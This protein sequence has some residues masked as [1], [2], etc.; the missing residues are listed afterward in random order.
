M[1][2]FIKLRIDTEPERILFHS[3]IEFTSPVSLQTGEIHTQRHGYIKQTAN[4]NGLV[5]DYIEN[6]NT[7]SNYFELSGSLHKY[8]HNGI[9]N[10]D[11]DLNELSSSIESVCSLLGIAPNQ[12]KVHRLEFGVNVATNY[13]TNDVL[14][15]I[16]CYMGKPY[17]LREFNGN[18]YF[19]RFALSQ[20]DVKIYNKALQYGLNTNILRFEIKVNRMD[21]L[22]KKGVQIVSIADLL[23]PL[24]NQQLRTQLNNT[25][26]NLLFIDYRINPKDICSTRDRNVILEGSNPT[27]WN[28][29]RKNHSAK[30][31]QKKVERFKQLVL[32][33]SQ[34]DLKKE[35]NELIL[36]KWDLLNSTPI[37][38]RVIN[39]IVPQYDIHIVG[40]I[41]ELNKRYCLTCGRE[42][43]QQKKGSK[44]CSENIYGPL[45]KGCR[46]KATNLNRD[47][48]RKYPNQTLFDIDIYLKPELRTI[49]QHF[50]QS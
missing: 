3:G 10:N 11:F 46:N 14:D 32:H 28:K 43:T 31:Y 37:L 18:G 38:Q 13:S 34:S 17:E 23:N 7:K 44:F 30:G 33:H 25:F 39:T 16:I 8:Y 5:I 26:A 24:I 35:I 27:F 6:I 41:K 36:A 50:K 9:N 20:Y 49:K 45:G 48:K 12:T 15:S 4:I 29:Y 42:I 21:Y 1:I 19:K 47:E 2:D 40:N 22:L